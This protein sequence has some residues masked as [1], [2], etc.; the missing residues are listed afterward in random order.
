MRVNNFNC[1]RGILKSNKWSNLFHLSTNQFIA[2]LFVGVCVIYCFKCQQFLQQISVAALLATAVPQHRKRQIL[3][4]LL[5]WTRHIAT[6]KL[7]LTK[8]DDWR[9]RRQQQCCYITITTQFEATFLCT[10]Q[11]I[12]NRTNIRIY[13]IVNAEHT[14]IYLYV[15]YVC[16]KGQRKLEAKNRW[17]SQHSTNILYIRVSHATEPSDNSRKM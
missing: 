16:T 10:A 11:R 13:T 9:Q 6:L 4:N 14:N 12:G 7:A 3:Y 2:P 15:P 1:H 5:T 17:S 8:T